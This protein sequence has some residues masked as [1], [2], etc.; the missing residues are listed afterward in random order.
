MAVLSRSL[1]GSVPPRIP[2]K[3]AHQ[4]C[5]FPGRAVLP[6]QGLARGESP[7][8]LSFLQGNPRPLGLSLREGSSRPSNPAEGRNPRPFWRLGASLRC[9]AQRGAH[10]QRQSV[11][12]A[13]SGTRRGGCCGRPPSARPIARRSG[14]RLPRQPANPCG[15]ASPGRRGGGTGGGRGGGSCAGTAGRRLSLDAPGAARASADPRTGEETW[16]C[17]RHGGGASGGLSG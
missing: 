15:A 5:C 12:A 1:P 7:P 11:L 3:R 4:D 6:A 9:A 13:G 14:L 2:G 10:S 17:S 16:R 8:T